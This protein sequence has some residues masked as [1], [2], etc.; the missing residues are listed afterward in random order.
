MLCFK[1]TFEL[2]DRAILNGKIRIL[3]QLLGILLENIYKLL[4]LDI[5]LQRFLVGVY[6]HLRCISLRHQVLELSVRGIATHTIGTIAAIAIEETD[7]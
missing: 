7:A 2:V 5:H 3:A 1:K 4:W 6:N